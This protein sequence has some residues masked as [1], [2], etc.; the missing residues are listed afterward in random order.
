MK[1]T[2]Y[3]RPQFIRN[4]WQNLNGK[5]G[6]AF[7][8]E[9]IG[10]IE[11]FIEKGNFPLRIEV[12]FCF[13][14]KESGINDEGFHDHIWYS[15]TIILNKQDH[16]GRV[17]L[18]FG[19]CDYYT[20]LY[21]NKTRVGSHEGGHTSFSFDITD[22]LTYDNEKVVIYVY[23]PSRSSSLPRGKQYWKLKPESIWYPRTTGIWQTIWLEYVPEVYITSGKST[24]L[25]DRGQI[26]FDLTVNKNFNGKLQIAISD[27][28]QVIHHY[29]HE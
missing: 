3:P 22:Y 8:D 2:G 16:R 26:R 6:F 23:D 27:E 14:S 17:L 13:Q 11:K 10:H 28:N 25:Y 1:S 5:W 19:A 18:H 29:F 7:D 9:N 12:P 21:I 24:P 15:K 4:E 20:E